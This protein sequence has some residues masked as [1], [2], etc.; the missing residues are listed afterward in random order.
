MEIMTGKFLQK[1]KKPNNNYGQTKLDVEKILAKKY[2]TSNKKWKI[3]NLRYFNLGA[4]PSGIL[5]EENFNSSTNLF[6]YYVKLFLKIKN[7]KFM[8]MIGIRQMEM[9]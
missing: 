5:G 7:L 8:V 2:N 4:H 6:H 1:K 9:Y 3:I